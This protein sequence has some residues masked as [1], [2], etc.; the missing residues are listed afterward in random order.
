MAGRW[1]FF[2]DDQ[3]WNGSR[4]LFMTIR[5]QARRVSYVKPFTIVTSAPGERYDEAT[6]TESREEQLDLMGDVTG[7]LQASLDA[8]WDLGM[9][10]K[11]YADHTNELKA[12]RYHLEDMRTLAVP[13]KE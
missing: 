9:R 12:V 3:P 7:F 1:A 13:K 2:V 11:A 8:A 4:R 10:P 6:L 5:D